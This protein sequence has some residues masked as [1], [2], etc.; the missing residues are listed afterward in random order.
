M[1]RSNKLLILLFLFAAS[2][3]SNKAIYMNAQLNAR[4]ECHFGPMSQYQECIARTNKS[5]EQYLRDRSEALGR[6]HTD[7]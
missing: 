5:Y 4:N 1:S 3:C 6:E 2:G 7:Y